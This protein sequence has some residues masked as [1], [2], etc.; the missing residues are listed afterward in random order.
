LLADKA[1]TIAELSAS[2]AVRTASTASG[3]EITTIYVGFVTVFDII[4]TAGRLYNKMCER[5][6][7]DCH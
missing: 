1:L 7:F 2:F 6:T 5:P 4:E 3:D